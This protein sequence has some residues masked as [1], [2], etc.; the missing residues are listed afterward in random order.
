M[1][2]PIIKKQ[3][4][5]INNDMDRVKT[6]IWPKGTYL[7]AGDSMLGHT[8]E[9]RMPKK[10]RVKV[11]LFPGSKTEDI[12][13]CIVPLLEKIL[14]YVIFHV[15]SNDAIDYVAS[16]IIKKILQVK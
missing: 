10:F 9:T 16:D 1:E 11:R 3:M 7:V 14:D 12:F 5:S 15:G 2:I 13:S 8:D 4:V 6:K